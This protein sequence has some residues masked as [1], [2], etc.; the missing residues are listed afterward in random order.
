MST[1]VTV[2]GWE[3]HN[4]P[5]YIADGERLV[6]ATDETIAEVADSA[7]LLSQGY[8]RAARLLGEELAYDGVR[9]LSG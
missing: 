2:R 8:E 6:V 1:V 4:A 3:D 9:G 7:M 5:A